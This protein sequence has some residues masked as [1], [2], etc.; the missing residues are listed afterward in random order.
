M[1]WCS[2]EIRKNSSPGFGF[3]FKRP[4]WLAGWFGLADPHVAATLSVGSHWPLTPPP[5]PPPP[6]YKQPTHCALGTSSSLLPSPSLPTSHT[7]CLAACTL[8]HSQTHP[9]PSTHNPERVHSP[10]ERPC[11]VRGSCG[12]FGVS[13]P[14]SG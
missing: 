6:H 5:P 2:W 3:G 13:L 4:G 10:P 14:Q 11:I 9:A 7:L 12:G 8:A 1:L